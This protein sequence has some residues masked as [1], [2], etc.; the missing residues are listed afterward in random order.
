VTI[1]EGLPH[2]RIYLLTTPGFAC[3]LRPE[4]PDH[5]VLRYEPIRMLDKLVQYIESLRCERHTIFPAPQATVNDVEPGSR[6]SIVVSARPDV[7]FAKRK[8]RPALRGCSAKITEV[9]DVSNRT[10]RFGATVEAPVLKP[11][12]I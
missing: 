3:V 4:S 5:P 7:G 11:R 12:P 10:R 6:T 1:T 2:P 8:I 9:D